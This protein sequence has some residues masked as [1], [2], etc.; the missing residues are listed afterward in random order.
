MTDQPDLPLLL[1]PHVFRAVQNICSDALKFSEG[2]TQMRAQVTALL[3]LLR[4]QGNTLHGCDSV[5]VVALQALLRRFTPDAA[6]ADK[7]VAAVVQATYDPIAVLVDREKL[8]AE[9]GDAAGVI[10]DIWGAF[11]KYLAVAGRDYGKGGGG[12]R[13]RAM[14]P[15]DVMGDSIYEIWRTQYVPWQ[16]RARTRRIA[17]TR[18]THLQMTLN[19]IND[20]YAPDMIDK[21]WKLKPDSALTVLKAELTDFLGDA[22]MA[23]AQANTALQDLVN[24]APDE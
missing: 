16:A 8:T 13:G 2:H 12:S 9:Q 14:S 3:T 10:R 5:E 6:A 11:S 4:K 23:I 7:R 1:E 18:L 17:G 21:S 24:G 19:V 22:G 20:H 15:L